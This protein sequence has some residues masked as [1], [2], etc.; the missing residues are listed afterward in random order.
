MEIG[1]YVRCPISDFEAPRNFIVGKIVELDDF[2]E[3]VTIAF[4][5]PY[6]Y[7]NYYENIPEH[8][9]FPYGY[10]RRSVL[11]RGA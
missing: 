1:M 3:R 8:A 2:T 10:I 9:E 4:F 5:D 11:H 6:G 7:R